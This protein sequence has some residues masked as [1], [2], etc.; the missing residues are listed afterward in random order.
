LWSFNEERVARAIANCS[1]PVISAV[2]HETDFTIADFVADLRAPTPSAAAEIVASSRQSMIDRINGADYKLRQAARLT[3][4]LLSR[5]YH[6]ASVDPARVHRL[7]G[8]RVQALDDLDY[9]AKEAMRAILARRARSLNLC[10]AK[11]RHL[12]VRV[13]FGQVHRRLAE[14]RADMMRVIRERLNRS[15]GALGLAAAHLTQLSPLK[16]IER[17]YAIVENQGRLVK[18]PTDAPVGAEVRVRLAAG[19]LAAKVTK[20]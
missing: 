3:L 20:S 1:V 5:R 10:S 19:E 4:A 9:R 15:G 8:R 18:S 2:G 12:D 6:Q 13:K 7:M 17:G 16:I 14:A 11:L